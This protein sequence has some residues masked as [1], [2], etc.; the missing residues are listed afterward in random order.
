MEN[1]SLKDNHKPVR[2]LKKRLIEWDK[3]LL[4]LEKEVNQQFEKVRRNHRDQ[5]ADIRQVRILIKESL[6]QFYQMSDTTLETVEQSIN[7]R[8]EQLW[9]TIM[10]ALEN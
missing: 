1:L 6:D 9:D 3:R 5:L 8:E 7:M 4:E 2:E 10:R